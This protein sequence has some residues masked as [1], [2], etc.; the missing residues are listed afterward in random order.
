M[1]DQAPGLT[2]E[3]PV[4]TITLR[5]VSQHNRIAPDDSVII[6]NHL[7]QVAANPGVRVLIVTGTGHKTFSSGY[8]LDAIQDQLDSRFEDMLDHIEQFPLPTIC[9]LNG[10]KS[11]V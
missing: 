8:T 3:G 1:E 6:C 4:A 5:R 10:R 7:S 9:V 11:V 2:I